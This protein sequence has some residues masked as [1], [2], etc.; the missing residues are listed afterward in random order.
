MKPFS[1]MELPE[2]LEK[3]LLGKGAFDFETSYVFNENIERVWIFLRD[4]SLIEKVNP[5]LITQFQLKK[6][7]NSWTVGNKFTSYWIGVSQIESECIF[8]KT[9]TNLKVIVWKYNLQINLFFYKCLFIYKITED[10][11]TLATINIKTPLDENEYTPYYDLLD[12]YKKL[13]HDLLTLY[14]KY[15]KLSNVSI[16]NYESTIV[17]KNIKFVWDFCTNLN[18]ITPIWDLLKGK[19]EYYGDL[20]QK[21]TFIRGNNAEGKTLYL[22]VNDVQMNEK[23]NYW[24]YSIET[25]GTAAH[26]RKQEIKLGIIKIDENTSQVSFTHSF[27]ENVSREIVIKRSNNNK[28]F[29][30]KLKGM[31][32]E[33]SDSKN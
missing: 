13:Y 11:S 33:N 9:H 24:F 16:I 28:I 23:D 26:L 17:K 15:M 31:F 29:L 6:G 8:S 14:A 7:N 22:Q 12:G 21:G 18:N 2:N 30:Q 19:F 4:V 1:K 32:E 25:F 10:D 3:S 20:F 27:H 5:N